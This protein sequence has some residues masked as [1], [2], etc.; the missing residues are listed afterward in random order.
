M[1]VETSAGPGMRTA[2]NKGNFCCFFGIAVSSVRD[3]WRRGLGP[4][5]PAIRA[6][7]AASWYSGGLLPPSGGPQSQAPKALKQVGGQ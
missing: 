1:R 4:K 2:L 5:A 7:R 6:A 3:P